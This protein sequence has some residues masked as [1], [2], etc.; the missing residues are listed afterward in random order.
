MPL[1]RNHNFN[2]NDGQVDAE[3]DENG[4]VSL[5]YETKFKML[6]ISFNLKEFL[7]LIAKEKHEN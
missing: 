2:C 5:V 6:L 7:Q 3:V 4:E 1:K